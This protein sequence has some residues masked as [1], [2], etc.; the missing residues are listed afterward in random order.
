MANIET[1]CDRCYKQPGTISVTNC[2]YDRIC[3]GCWDAI[4]G[5]TAAKILDESERTKTPATDRFGQLN[6]EERD[7]LRVLIQNHLNTISEISLHKDFRVIGYLDWLA[8]IELELIGDNHGKEE[9]KEESQE[10]G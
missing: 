8:K 2:N 9:N 10:V 5:E 6:P 1:F 3:G 4:C 7:A